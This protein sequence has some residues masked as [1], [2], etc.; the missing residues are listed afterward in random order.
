MRPT[1]LAAVLKAR[2]QAHIAGTRMRP[3]YIEGSPGVGKTQLLSQVANELVIGYMPIHAPL[4]LNEDFGM[5]RFSDGGVEFA[6]PEGKFPFEGNDKVPDH[7]IVAV[8]EAPQCGPDQQKIWANIFQ[9]RELHG[10]KIKPGWSFIA[11]GNRM[12]DRAGAGRLL[13]HF[14]DRFTTYEFEPNLDDWAAWALAHDVRPEVVFFCRF[15][16]EKFS[17]FDPQQPKCPTPRAWVEGVS[18]AIDVVPRPALLSTVT[19]DVGASAAAEF[20]GFLNTY[21]QLPDPD[22]VIAQADTWPVPD[23]LQVRFALCGALAHRANEDNFGSIITFACR[24]P[25][26]FMVLCIRDATQMHTH[27]R[28]TRDYVKWTAGRGGDALLNA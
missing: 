2:T 25:D 28:Q 10:R 22:L 1:E 13:S 26:E 18:P 14:N 16:P 11:T 23:Q 4:M 5:P 19:G 15:R 3:A 12:Q 21:E 20:M 7:G 24:L 6:V 9:E 27:L 8:D 17:A